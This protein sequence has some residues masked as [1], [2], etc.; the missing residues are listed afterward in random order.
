MQR[1]VGV[2]ATGK[3]FDAINASDQS[4][5]SGHI[6]PMVNMGAIVI[7]SLIHGGSYA[8]RFQ[9]LL[10]LTR[11][12]AGDE[13]IGID[14]DV[15]HSEKSHG[16]KNRALAYLLKS[17]GLL[18]DDVE[19]VL[20]CYF[21]ACSIRVDCRALAHIGAVLSNRGRLPNSSRQIFPAELARY[22]NAI[23]TTCGMYDGSGEFA[24]E[25][26]I[27]SK[28]GVGG[29]ILSVVDRKMGIG[30]YGPS[31]DK[32]GNSIGGKAMLKYVSEELNLHMFAWE[33]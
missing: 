7:C 15:Y 6:N 12:L 8:E 19:E 9:R 3:T 2:E 11:L 33:P 25:V 26:G 5:D 18:D 4:L 10:E 14:E 23:L 31:L 16:S 1:R 13:R 24:V 20:D 21:R 22:V 17:Y 30:I 27:P 32:K 28:S 29:G